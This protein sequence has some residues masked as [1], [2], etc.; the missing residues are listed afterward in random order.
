M[1]MTTAFFTDTRFTQHTLTGHPEHAG[2]LIAIQ[3]LLEES[4]IV[5]HFAR[6]E[7]REATLEEIQRVHAEK[8]LDVLAWIAAQERMV[9]LDPDTYVLPVS[10]E[11]ARIAAGGL[12]NVVDAVL[13][14]QAD[15]GLAAIRP[16]GHHATPTRGMGFCLLN[17]IAIAARYA[18]AKYGLK[19]VAIVD[20]DVHHGNGTQ[21]AFYDDA[22]VYFISS[23]QAPPLYPGTGTVNEIGQGTGQGFNMNIPL[24]GGAGDTAF[25]TLYTRLVLPALARFQP[26]MILVSAGFDA[27][28]RDPL[29]SLQVSLPMFAN[30][31]CW[32]IQTAQ[33]LCEGR[34]V[35]VTEGGYDLEVLSNGVLNVGYALLG[36]DTVQDPIGKTDRNNPLDNR[37]LEQL[38]KLHEL[39]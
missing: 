38:L 6:V 22:S 26:E 21:D 34:I 23:H 10:Y 33:T 27:H 35:F 9:G 37:L 1:T 18:Q 29:A 36:Q 16:P 30:I 12:L 25:E 13:E 4:G 11:L 24:P 5:Q 39:G 3:N 32:L 14:K 19:K 17:N 8:Y 2:R 20:F 28:W 7:P 31:T 15:N